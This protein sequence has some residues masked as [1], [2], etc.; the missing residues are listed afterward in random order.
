[1]EQYSFSSSIF[2]PVVP[3]INTAITSIHDLPVILIL[4][5]NSC[6][7]P[8]QLVG[9]KT[10][11]QKKLFSGKKGQESECYF[12]NNGPLEQWPF[13]FRIIDCRKN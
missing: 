9:A 10:K 4:G 6:S 7:K 5:L 11:F 3:K 8:E 13:V 12:W 1:M 2:A